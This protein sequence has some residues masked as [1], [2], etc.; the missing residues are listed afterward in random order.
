[1]YIK[2]SYSWFCMF[3]SVLKQKLQHPTLT[4]L[5]AMLPKASYHVAITSRTASFLILIEIFR[6]PYASDTKYYLSKV[7]FVK[8]MYTR[9][10][11]V[12]Y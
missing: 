11:S 7:G 4:Y 3:F 5:A 10:H 8:K 9:V 6:R 12:F 1:M 2:T